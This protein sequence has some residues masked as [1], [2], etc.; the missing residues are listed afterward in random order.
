MLRNNFGRIGKPA[1]HAFSQIRVGR[2]QLVRQILH[3]T[4]ILKIGGGHLGRKC[5]EN[6]MNKIQ[7]FTGCIR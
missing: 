5:A 3:E 7:R 4:P 6:L 1:R 2:G